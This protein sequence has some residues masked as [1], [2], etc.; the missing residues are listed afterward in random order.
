MDKAKVAFLVV[1]ILLFYFLPAIIA[2]ARRHRQ[3]AA[4]TLVNLLLGWTGLGWVLVF[5][6]SWSP[7]VKL[8]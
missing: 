5:F 1:L 8:I 3:I 7:N 2:H 4:I 6:W